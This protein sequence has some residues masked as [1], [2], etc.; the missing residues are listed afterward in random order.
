M[1]AISHAVEPTRSGAETPDP[2]AALKKYGA[3]LTQCRARYWDTDGA[4]ILGPKSAKPGD[5]RVETGRP[6]SCGLDGAIDA[7]VAAFDSGI[8]G[9]TVK[10]GI[11]AGSHAVRVQVLP[12]DR[13]DRLPGIRLAVDPGWLNGIGSLGMRYAIDNMHSGQI[14]MRVWTAPMTEAER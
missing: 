2:I 5:R 10:H 11:D 3:H 6:C 1:K 14:S 13:A 7:G 4:L 12:D 9:V 8:W